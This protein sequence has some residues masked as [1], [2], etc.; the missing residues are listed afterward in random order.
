MSSGTRLDPAPGARPAEQGEVLLEVR[1]LEVHFPIKSGVIFDRTVG[2]VRAV[3]GVDLTI[4]R[5]ETYGLVGESG[6]GKSTLGKAILNLE[7]PTAGSVVFDGVDIASLKGEELPHGAQAIPDGLP[8]PDVEPRPAAD[9]GGAAARGHARPRPRHRQVRDP[10]PAAR[11]DVGRR[12]ALRPALRKYPHEFSGG[13]RQRIG[14]ARALSVGPDLIVADEPVSAL[15]VSIQAQVINLLQDLQD[16]LGLT[17]LVV[18]HDLGRGAPHQRPDRRDVPRRARRGV[19]GRRAVRRTAPPLHAGA[20]VGGAGAGPAGRGHARA[21]PADRRPALA[22][23]PADRVPLPH[24]VP[25]AA[26]DTLRHRATAAAGR[27]GRRGRRPATGSRAT[28]PSRSRRARSSRH[29]VDATL[30]TTAGP[31]S[32]DPTPAEPPRQ[33]NAGDAP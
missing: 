15:D 1:G 17:Y 22:G 30:V 26:G 18:A 25:V 11:A 19:G 32:G 9:G 23:Q 2:H 16:E 4:H 28:S 13:Q 7:A 27:R 20:H 10:R 3:D 29:E 6:C 31:A 8:G 12:A 14:I 21:D 33:M 24:P 5:G